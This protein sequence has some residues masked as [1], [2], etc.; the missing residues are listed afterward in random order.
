MSY[1]ENVKHF[2]VIFKPLDLQYSLEVEASVIMNKIKCIRRAAG[3]QVSFVSV[4]KLKLRLFSHSVYMDSN[5]LHVDLVLNETI[6]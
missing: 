1:E 3:L 4:V 5:I 2:I 6:K